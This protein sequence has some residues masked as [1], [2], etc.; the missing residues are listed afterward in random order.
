MAEFIAYSLRRM[1]HA[2]NHIIGVSHVLVIVTL[3]AFGQIAVM[4]IEF[5]FLL[6]ISH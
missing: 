5:W 6:F 2:I 1:V 4:D 3:F